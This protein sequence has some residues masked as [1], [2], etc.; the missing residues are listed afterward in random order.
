MKLEL[1]KQYNL[2]KV[3]NINAVISCTEILSRVLNSNRSLIIV[4]TSSIQNTV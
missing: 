3:Y 1:N 2:K 4:A